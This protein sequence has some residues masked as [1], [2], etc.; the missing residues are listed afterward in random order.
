MKAFLNTIQL[1]SRSTPVVPHR[2]SPVSVHS[3]RSL[4]TPLKTHRSFLECPPSPAY[5][6]GNGATRMS[7]EQWQAFKRAWWACPKPSSFPNAD[8][9]THRAAVAKSDSVSSLS[10]S[11]LRS[12]RSKIL[13]PQQNSS[14]TV[15]EVPGPPLS[16]SLLTLLA[17]SMPLTEPL[18]NAPLQAATMSHPFRA[19]N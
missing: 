3:H 4:G 14:Q 8:R 13:P 11:A 6:K 2:N 16:R 1:P 5:R 7:T 10:A 19:Q 15:L 9:S 17:P 12:P 18:L